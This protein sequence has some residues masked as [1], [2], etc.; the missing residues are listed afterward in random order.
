M[1]TTSEDL[2]SNESQN[3]ANNYTNDIRKYRVFKNEKEA[4]TRIHLY[5]S[6]FHCDILC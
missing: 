2:P 6:L 1:A 5:I 3:T 4:L